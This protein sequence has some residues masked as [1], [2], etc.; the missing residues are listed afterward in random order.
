MAILR[1]PSINCVTIGSM[2]RAPYGDATTG[3]MKL[4]KTVRLLVNLRF[5]LCV[6]ISIGS[7]GCADS[8]MSLEE[9]IAANREAASVA[10]SQPSPRSAEDWAKRAFVPERVGPS[11]VLAVA[12]TGLTGDT[13]TE[14]V[15]VR[16]N[17]E[18]EIS[19]PIAGK[20]KVGGL[21]LED[22][23]QTIQ[24][25]YVPAIIK[26]L[27]VQVEVVSYA[28]TDVIVT[29]AV[30]APG[31]TS[32]RRNERDLLHAV[33]QAGGVSFE[34]SGRLSLRPLRNPAEEVSID[35]LSSADRDRV[36][37][38]EPLESGDLIIVEAARSNTIFVGGLVNVPGPQLYP[39]G[40][41]INMLQ[42]LA[43]AGGVREN[44]FPSSATL[45]RR[46]PDGRDLQVEI[47]LDRLKTGRDP[48]IML[49]AGDILWVPETFGTR[50][51]DFVNQNIFFR[52]GFTASYN[53]TGNATGV[54]FLNRR[55]AQSANLTN[56][57]GGTTL[58][59]RVDPLGFL[60]P[61]N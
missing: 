23:E 25:R 29:G 36:F 57:T 2:W 15:Q 42:T 56:S 26:M 30:A 8:Y 46:M 51:M 49:A 24:E 16:V 44:L 58:Q 53:V 40:T 17:R 31:L 43:A 11:D 6:L 21:E 59:N 35:L 50:F 4:W 41:E 20:V 34:A 52:A 33:A 45:I 38:L 18:G 9:F 1:F 7:V 3:T 27:P 39:A 5:G 55:A 61:R 48:N 37:S 13:T 19:L 14:I 54:E 60:V 32:L 22:V 47:D 28:T 10:T 12:L